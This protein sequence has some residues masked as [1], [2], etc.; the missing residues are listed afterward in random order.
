[1]TAQFNLRALEEELD[2]LAEAAGK[3]RAD[4]SLS[5]WLIELGLARAAELGIKRAKKLQE[6]RP[7]D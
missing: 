3:D 2:V 4:K 5:R 7:S 6:S 1:M